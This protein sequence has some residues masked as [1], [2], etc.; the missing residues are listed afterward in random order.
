MT[1]PR[2]FVTYGQLMRSIDLAV[3]A[4]ALAGVAATLAARLERTRDGL[5]QAGIELE[6][7]RT[8]DRTTVD[9]LEA[10][11][12]FGRADRH[13]LRAEISAL[14]ADLAAVGDLQSWV[15]ARLFEAREEAA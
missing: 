1:D 4:D 9:R 5:R 8:F 11:G 10:V 2:V 12:A 15:E 3:Y 7:R 6:A 13:A 14:E